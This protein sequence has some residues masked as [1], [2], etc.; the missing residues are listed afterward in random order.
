MTKASRQK[1]VAAACLL[2][3]VAAL[4]ARKEIT[5]ASEPKSPGIRKRNVAPLGEHSIYGGHLNSSSEGDDCYFSATGKP[6]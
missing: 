2:M 4:S 3:G 5:S 1:W 6:S